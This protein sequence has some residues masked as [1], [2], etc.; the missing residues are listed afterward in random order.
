MHIAKYISDPL[1][2]VI[3]AENILKVNKTASNPFNSLFLPIF[4]L[5]SS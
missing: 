5:E 4:Q 3:P 2:A 1:Y